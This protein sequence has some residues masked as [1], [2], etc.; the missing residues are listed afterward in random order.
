MYSTFW[1]HR[2]ALLLPS[3][4]R[5]KAGNVSLMISDEKAAMHFGRSTYWIYNHSEPFPLHSCQTSE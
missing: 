3:H 2:V 5:Y 1:Y 4:A